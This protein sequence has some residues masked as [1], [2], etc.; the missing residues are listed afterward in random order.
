MNDAPSLPWPFKPGDVHPYLNVEIAPSEYVT[1]VLAGDYKNLIA[2]Y[3]QLRDEY[4]RLTLAAQQQIE[5]ARAV[6]DVW[7]HY[8]GHE[9]A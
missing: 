2:E 8:G 3:L 4:Q 6:V 1:V 9:R 7:M 5:A